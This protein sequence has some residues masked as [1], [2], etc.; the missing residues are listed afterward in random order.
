MTIVI[1]I[2]YHCYIYTV[3]MQEASMENSS[4]ADAPTS[5]KAQTVVDPND[6]LVLKGHQSEVFSCSWN[7]VEPLLLASG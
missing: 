7:P 5:A 1:I 2:I 6:V 3:E 4:K